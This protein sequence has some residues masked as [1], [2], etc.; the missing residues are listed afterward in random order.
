MLK[1]GHS[2]DPTCPAMS[3]ELA[4]VPLRYM[5]AYGR[6]KFC[7][8]LCETMVNTDYHRTQVVQAQAAAVQALK[9]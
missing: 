2:D 3:T 6:A 9:I 5:S 8:S 1:I 4:N 7:N